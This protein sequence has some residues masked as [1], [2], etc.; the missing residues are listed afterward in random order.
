MNF[1]KDDTVVI[2]E[3][4]WQE[5]NQTKDITLR[6]Y[7][8]EAYLYIV[9]TNIKK[10]Y[11]MV[12]NQQDIEDMTNQGVLE[13][14]NCIERYDYKRGIQFDTFASIRVRGSIIDYVRKKDWIPRDTRKKVK[15]LNESETLFMNQNG[16]TPT[17]SELALQLNIS[18]EDVDKLRQDEL[19]SKLFAFEELIQDNNIQL[20]EN[21]STVEQHPEDK[22]L[23]DEFK[24]VLAQHIDQLDKNER[25]VISLYYYEELKLKE[26]AFVMGLTASRVSQ[27]H[28]KALNKLKERLTAYV[29][30]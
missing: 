19:N 12:S 8:L 7:I 17:E 1:Y 22:I 27:I 15:E 5:Y 4:T 2:I 30:T 25:T 9:S 28:A 14:I 11:T 10:M 29:M 6:N 21:S 18:E 16:R 24:E 20:I 13:L 3:K 23:E 26:I